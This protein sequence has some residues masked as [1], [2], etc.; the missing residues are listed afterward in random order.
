MWFVYT[1]THVHARVYIGKYLPLII[2]R[3]MLTDEN[4]WCVDDYTIGTFFPKM[5]G[6]H[7]F[8]LWL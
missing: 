3:A 1:C 8:V 2:Q 4:W 5:S 7:Y 6:P